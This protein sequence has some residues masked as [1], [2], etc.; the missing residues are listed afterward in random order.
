MNRNRLKL[1]GENTEFLL[2]DTKANT[3]K[4][5]ILSIQIC[6]STVQATSSAK[7]L[8]FTQFYAVYTGPTQI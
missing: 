5:R 7:N 4:S 3:E 2:I 6:G 8:G 1:N